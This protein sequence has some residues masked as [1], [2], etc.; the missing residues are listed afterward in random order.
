MT[1]NIKPLIFGLLLA[2]LLLLSTS[3]ITVYGIANVQSSTAYIPH[4]GH[5]DTA[6]S[7]KKATYITGNYSSTIE[8]AAYEG[9]ESS[10]MVGLS[11]NRSIAHNAYTF[12]YGGF[13]YGG[14]YVVNDRTSAPGPKS[15]YGVGVTGGSSLRLGK[16]RKFLDLS[17]RMTMM[18][19]NGEYADFRKNFDSIDNFTDQHPNALTTHLV[20]QM[21][22]NFR[23]GKLKSGVYNSFGA[24]F[25]RSDPTPDFNMGLFFS[26]KRFMLNSELSMNGY[27]YS[28]LST[29]LTYRV[30]K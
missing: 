28:L 10:R 6:Q 12:T 25:G 5:A 30:S 19:E 18:Y 24:A 9:D 15:Y 4:P 1:P 7:V 22:F 8:D 3:C 20:G 29:G 27:D 23:I 16:R 21:I 2:P 14:R 13:G 11:V 17:V 26:H